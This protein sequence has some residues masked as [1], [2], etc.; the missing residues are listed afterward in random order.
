MTMFL[1]PMTMFLQP[2]SADE[3]DPAYPDILL[4][5]THALLTQAQFDALP[6]YS[7]SVPTGVIPG[8]TWKRLEPGRPPLIGRYD[9]SATKPET[10]CRLWFRQ[11]IIV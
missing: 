6:E 5:E 11:A 1:Q 2:P 7:Y 3:E 9:P 4:D 8:K 10:H